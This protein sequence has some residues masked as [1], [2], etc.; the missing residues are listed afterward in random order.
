MAV[1]FDAYTATA[2]TLSGSPYAVSHTP[3]GTPRGIIGIIQ[4]QG[5]AAYVSGA[6][7]GGDTMTLV[8]EIYRATG[9]HVAM[10]FLGT[11]IP[12][13]TQ[14]F[15][16]THSHF[17]NMYSSVISLTA[18]ADTE[19]VDSDFTTMVSDGLDD[20]STTLSLAGRSSFCALAGAFQDA[21]ADISP[22][23]SW[24]SRSELALGAATNIVYT[25]NTIGTAD[26]TAGVTTLSAGFVRAI[27]IA[28]AE[29]P[30]A[31]PTHPFVSIT[32]SG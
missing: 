27:A 7:Y 24:T 9:G 32:V 2:V 17:G 12:T 1:A 6:T 14:S 22:L 13:G 5:A 4:M 8:A 28:V 26:V 16:V 25:Y 10:Y 20:P 23:G 21:A 11:S 31:G 3:T 30:A 29:I 18:D 15:S 19:I